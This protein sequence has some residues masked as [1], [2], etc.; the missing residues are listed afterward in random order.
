[1][2]VKLLAP[3]FGIHLQLYVNEVNIPFNRVHV[4]FCHVI[5]AVLFP[6]VILD[7]IAQLFPK[8]RKFV[9][10]KFGH[11]K[12]NL[13]PEALPHCTVIEWI[14]LHFDDNI[15]NDPIFAQRVVSVAASLFRRVGIEMEF[16]PRI[17]HATC[18][19]CT[20]TACFR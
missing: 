11:V 3:Q 16:F 10:L 7:K 20:R 19:E 1:V 9:I 18:L 5:V 14:R 4:P 2:P 8:V 15:V 17:A 6:V 12:F 13:H